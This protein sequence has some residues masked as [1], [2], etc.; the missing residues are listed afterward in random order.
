MAACK[1]CGKDAGRLRTQCEDCRWRES[2]RAQEEVAQAVDAYRRQDEERRREHAAAQ[3][4]LI[5]TTL[6]LGRPAYLY[7]AIYIPVDS[8][9]N[10]EPVGVFDI[11]DLQGLG[12]EGWEIVATIPKTLGLG[13]ANSSFGS[14]MGTTWGGGMGGNVVGVYVLMK[15]PVTASSVDAL[16]SEVDDFLMGDTAD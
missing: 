7:Q 10:E 3:W 15:F 9:V 14:T 13:L 11:T 6:K 8:T 5:E 1:T 2:L 4:E 16:R 12:Y